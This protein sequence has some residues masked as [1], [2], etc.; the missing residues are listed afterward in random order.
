MFFFFFFTFVLERSRVYLLDGQR[1]R[2]ADHA[3]GLRVAD[4]AGPSP[5]AGQVAENEFVRPSVRG[6]LQQRQHGR[7]KHDPPMTYSAADKPATRRQNTLH[8]VV[9]MLFICCLLQLNRV[10]RVIIIIT[11]IITSDRN[12]NEST[13]PVFPRRCDER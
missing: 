8:A 6:Q 4:V 10:C 7:P 1:Y 13:A 9:R 3:A 5:R 2:A 12:G 11:I